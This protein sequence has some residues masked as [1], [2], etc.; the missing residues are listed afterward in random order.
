MF[1]HLLLSLVLISLIIGLFFYSKTW[2]YH[3]KLHPEFKRVFDVLDRILTPILDFLKG[4]MKPYEIGV[5]VSLDMSQ[6]IL[7]ALLLLLLKLI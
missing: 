3:A 1:F 5:G 7:L 4:I 6:F 2:N